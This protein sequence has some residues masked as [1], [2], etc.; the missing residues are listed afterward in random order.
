MHD[1]SVTVVS[2]EFISVSYGVDCDNRR[3]ISQMG[4]QQTAS[5]NHKF[6]IALVMGFVVNDGG[7]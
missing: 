2:K 1:V 3:P 6:T 7:G 5:L 4:V